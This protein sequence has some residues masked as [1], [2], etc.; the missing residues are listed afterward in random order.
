MV[1]HSALILLEPPGVVP[2]ESLRGDD[3]PLANEGRTLLAIGAWKA[4]AGCLDG[5][6][7]AL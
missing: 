2:G 5:V 1:Q 4:F 6:L 7:T 3:V